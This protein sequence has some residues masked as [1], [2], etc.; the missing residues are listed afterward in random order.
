MEAGLSE[1][2][3][4][5]Q[6][7]FATRSRASLPTRP[8]N[9]RQ[10]VAALGDVVA[11]GRS[12]RRR[13]GAPPAPRLALTA[14]GLRRDDR[15][16]TPIAR[17]PTTIWRTTALSR[18]IPR[19]REENACQEILYEEYHPYGTT[20]YRSSNGSVDVSARRYRYTGKERDDE[21]GLYYNGARYLAAWLG[22]WT[23]A[24]PIGIGAD[25]PGLYNYTRGSPVNY[26]DPSGTD[27]TSKPN[28]FTGP[29]GKCERVNPWPADMA[30]P[31]VAGP[32]PYQGP[33]V[34]PPPAKE[35]EAPEPEQEQLF[36]EGGAGPGSMEGAL[37]DLSGQSGAAS[38]VEETI[39]RTR[40]HTAS[41]RALAV[42]A[43]KLGGI[44][45]LAPFVTPG[46]AVGI[47]AVL[48]ALAPTPNESAGNL[49]EGLSLGV[50][51]KGASA[52]AKR[53]GE[54]VLK[55]AS[56]TRNTAPLTAPQGRTAVRTAEE[57]GMPAENIGIASGRTPTAYAPGDIDFLV[58]GRDVLPEASGTGTLTANSRVTMRGA[59]GHEIIGHREAALA[60]RTHADPLLEEVQAS[61]RGARFTPGL[62]S[63]E[64]VTLLRDAIARLA[65]AGRRWKDVRP[66][67]HIERR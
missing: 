36:N 45:I 5:A 11:P 61:V 32:A 47:G 25:G 60:G 14:R 34:G 44:A 37:S 49:A 15:A 6:R 26:V 17:S 51:G 58:I 24:D 22:R 42:G 4:G 55:V 3:R 40:A 57:L 27:S 20:A 1:S 46:V 35:P 65:K 54:P 8:Q 31:P 63:T 2:Q 10:R 38:T 9:A 48:S 16:R 33:S 21:T 56:G 66:S 52:T 13:R 7:P 53:S 50:G 62:S 28:P 29:A 23:S 64:R 30:Q 18:P 67:L 12:H 39:D 43:A 41:E 59:L 19:S